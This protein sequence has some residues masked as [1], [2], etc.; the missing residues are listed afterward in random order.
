[1]KKKLL[2]LLAGLTVSANAGMFNKYTPFYG[3]GFAATA[4]GLGYLI[5]DQIKYGRKPATRSAK[6]TTVQNQRRQAAISAV[7]GGLAVA[8]TTL[9]LHVKNG[10]GKP[11]IETDP[12]LD[13]NPD[14]QLTDKIPEAPAPM[15]TNKLIRE[16][17]SVGPQRPDITA[18]ALAGVKLRKISTNPKPVDPDPNPSAKEAEA[19]KN[20]EL[21]RKLDQELQDDLS[22]IQPLQ[23]QPELALVNSDGKEAQDLNDMVQAFVQNGQSFGLP[24][25]SD[26]IRPLDLIRPQ[27]LIQTLVQNGYT[28]NST[29]KINGTSAL[30][31]IISPK[32][33][34]VAHVKIARPTAHFLG[35]CGPPAP[36]PK[37]EADPKPDPRERQWTSEEANQLE[38][39]AY[40]KIA[41]R[42]V[43]VANA[44]EQH[45]NNLDMLD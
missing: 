11:G 24:R 43:A 5:Y 34:P 21:K 2:L 14:P 6:R 40:N 35:P 18:D 33:T 7:I 25:S 37:P 45:Q 17:K 36:D 38:Q 15:D 13:P 22:E 10:W 4:G 42:A 16:L 20:L 12:N 32:G 27:D 23:C 26:L 8:L 28:I 39:E 29:Q 30:I 31:E 9:G 3:V 1:M 44:D 19:Q 41:E